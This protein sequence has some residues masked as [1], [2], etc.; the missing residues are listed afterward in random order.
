MLGCPDGCLQ[1]I[2]NAT[3][4]QPLDQPLGV[5]LC[6]FNGSKYRTPFAYNLNSIIMTAGCTW[7]SKISHVFLNYRI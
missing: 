1:N 3:S 4:Y 2:L 6:N 7:N 5:L